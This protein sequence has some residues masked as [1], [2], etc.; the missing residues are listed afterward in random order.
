MKTTKQKM[1]NVWRADSKKTTYLDKGIKYIAVRV[2][3]LT[4]YFFPYP[5][6][7]AADIRVHLKEV[8]K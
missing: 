2:S 4:I 5:K 3:D 8:A 1:K 7:K 6:F